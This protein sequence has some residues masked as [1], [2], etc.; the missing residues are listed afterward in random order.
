MASTMSD[1]GALGALTDF[2]GLIVAVAER[3]DR[4]AFAILFG[5]FAPRVK[6]YLLRLGAPPEA[7]EELAQETLLTVWRR[8]ASYD[9]NR[10]AASTWIFTIAR[11]LRIDLIRRERRP[12]MAEDPS[13]VPEPEPAPDNAAIAAQQETRIAAA[14]KQLPP[15]Q[16]EV[17]RLSYFADQPHSEI[18]LS[19]KLPLGTVKS[20]VRLAMMRL[21]QLLDEPS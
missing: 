19:L 7:A 8:A 13:L 4:G 16:A 9:P 21:R 18:A 3:A 14:L 2:S 5:H 6:S 20:R 17:I 15:D 10:A 12:L 11:N 1:G